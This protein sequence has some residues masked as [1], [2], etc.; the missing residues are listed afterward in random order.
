[1]EKP[2]TYTMEELQ[3]LTGIDRRTIS[4]YTQEDLLPRVGRLG[5]RTRY[6]QLFL[7]R[8]RFIVRVRELEEAGQLSTRPLSEIR[9]AFSALTDEEIYRVG[10]GEVEPLGVEEL[11]AQPGLGGDTRYASP[12]ELHD[13]VLNKVQSALGRSAG[14]KPARARKQYLMDAAHEAKMAPVTQRAAARSWYLQKNAL[15]EIG[16]MLAQLE[17]EAQGPQRRST[18]TERW[19]RVPVNENIVLSVRNLDE[20]HAPAA[21]QVAKFLKALLDAAKSRREQAPEPP[22]QEHS[23]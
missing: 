20:R 10:A 6:P 23:A 12:D 13:G 22:G 5:P 19:L 15:L 21:E 3:R 14:M 9:E 4:Y 17:A 16:E 11:F 2:R 18:S 1:M 8:L 7:D